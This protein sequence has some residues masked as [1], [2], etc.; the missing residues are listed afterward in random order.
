MKKM[1]ILQNKYLTFQE[2]YKQIIE[3]K[4]EI[5]FKENLLGYEN[6][7]IL[8]KICYWKDGN[9]KY[10]ITRALTDKAL[11][12]I[13]NNNIKF[14]NNT[15]IE[16]DTIRNFKNLI[17]NIEVYSH[18]QRIDL[19][20][21][22]F[23]KQNNII[24]GISYNEKELFENIPIYQSIP[25]F[26]DGSKF[27]KHWSSFYRRLY[28]FDFQKYFNKNNNPIGAEYIKEMEKHQKDKTLRKIMFPC[29][30]LDFSYSFDY[31]SFSYT[32]Y[33]WCLSLYWNSMSLGDKD[34]LFFYIHIYENRNSWLWISQNCCEVKYFDYI[35][36]S[37][38]FNQN[39]WWIVKKF[40]EKSNTCFQTDWI[41]PNSGMK[42]IFSCFFKS[43][44]GKEYNLIIPKDKT[45][46]DQIYVYMT[47]SYYNIYKLNFDLY[48][49]YNEPN[50]I[51]VTKEQRDNRSK[52]FK[53]NLDI[54][55]YYSFKL[56]NY[57]NWSEKIWSISDSDKSK[58]IIDTICFHYDLYRNTYII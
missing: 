30:E 12:F 48:R 21:F 41:K 18:L 55:K 34:L 28:N 3:N 20:K 5:Y 15:Y 45:D 31:T 46:S 44:F 58:K 38:K 9:Q 49:Q 8:W 26:G 27:E 22:W 52:K 51:F 29:L 57:I 23:I 36:T 7:S 37:E 6:F 50:S 40:K 35:W 19:T 10:F 32:T 42:S 56:S 53:E 24:S 39:S 16:N 1:E 13:K 4:K 54:Q 47:L 14:K 43:N 25:F 17:Q 33:L 2:A 11:E